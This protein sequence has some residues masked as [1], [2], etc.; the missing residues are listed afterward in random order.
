MRFFL[1][2]KDAPVSASAQPCFPLDINML[3]LLHVI[4]LSPNYER[5]CEKENNQTNKRGLPREGISS[6]I[7]MQS[8]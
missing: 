2:V 3:F 6:V 5:V 4:T 7:K 8:I 1:A